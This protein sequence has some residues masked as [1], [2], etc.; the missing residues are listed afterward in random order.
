MRVIPAI[1]LRGGRCVR[2]VQGRLDRETVYGDDPV[3]VARRW[4]AAGAEMLHV[5]DLDGAFG[6]VPRHL[7]VIGAIAAATGLPLQVGGGIRDLEAVDRVLGA[8]ARRVILGT[9]AVEEPALVEEA[10]AHYPGRILVGIDARG[11]RVAIKGWAEETA[12]PA[13]DLAAEMRERGVEEI[14]FTDIGRDGTLSGPN[15][16]ALREVA[17][18]G[19]RVIASGGV[20]ALD[21]VRR[22]RA[23]APAGVCGV[24]VGKALYTG[25]IDLAEA[26][27]AAR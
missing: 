7:E 18:A 27:A 4:Q 3:A 9:A 2:L 12:R 6:G 8:G 21:D 13:A 10:C 1:D 26:I 14:I 22:L 20:A 19:V 5:V 11:G 15:L 17:A 23:L 24:I 16:D 25:A